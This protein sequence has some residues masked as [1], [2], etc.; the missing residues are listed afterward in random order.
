MSDQT[1]SVS[2]LTLH[3]VCDKTGL[4]R[5]TIYRMVAAGQFPRQ[6]KVGARSLWVQSEVEAWILSR[7]AER[8][9]GESMGQRD[10]A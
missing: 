7:I 2:L 4:N 5:A 3:R 6:V 9:M 10:A 8:D 1:Q